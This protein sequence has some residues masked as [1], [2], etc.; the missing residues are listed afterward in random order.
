[1]LKFLS[2]GGA[3]AQSLSPGTALVCGDEKF[4]GIVPLI[5]QP[6]R[7]RS[8]AIRVNTIIETTKKSLRFPVVGAE[9]VGHPET[10][11]TRSTTASK[12]ARACHHKNNINNHDRDLLL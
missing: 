8:V 10:C 1:L 12:I 9:A 6:I 2:R 7:L 3:G 11:Q 4:I 5:I